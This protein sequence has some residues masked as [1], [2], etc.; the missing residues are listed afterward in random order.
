MNT[1]IPDF[2]IEFFD[3]SGVDNEIELSVTCTKRERLT[4]LSPCEFVAHTF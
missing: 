1:R 3:N 4:A 2:N